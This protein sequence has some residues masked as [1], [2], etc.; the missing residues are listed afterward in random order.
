[1]PFW[2]DQLR[3]PPAGACRECRGP[4]DK[5]SL[6]ICKGCQARHEMQGILELL[7]QGTYWPAVGEPGDLL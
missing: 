5:E 1:M 4:L 7:E 3:P 6:F 2:P